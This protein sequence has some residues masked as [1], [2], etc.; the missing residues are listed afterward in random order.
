MA[1]NANS[2]L[3]RI[4]QIS[5]SAGG[6]PKLAVP[7]AQVGSLG[8]LGDEHRDLKHHG[9]PERAVCLYSLERILALQAEG[10]PIFPGAAGEN[11]TLSG[12]PWELVVPGARLQVGKDLLLEVTK[13]TEPCNNIRRAFTDGQFMRIAQDMHPGWSR[14]Y[15]RVL[16]EGAIL[17]ADPVRLHSS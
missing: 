16:Q 17:P 2:N 15:A 13:Y 14:V 4:F 9:G 12:L 10:H 3:G 7:Q 6:V 11:L 1:S 5:L 8:L